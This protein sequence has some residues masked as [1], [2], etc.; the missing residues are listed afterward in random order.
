[1]HMLG[2]KQ[3]DFTV[4]YKCHTVQLITLSRKL[5]TLRSITQYTAFILCCEVSQTCHYI[6][7]C[8]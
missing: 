3:L 2:F 8:D 6:V 1:M 7:V 5:G 4:I